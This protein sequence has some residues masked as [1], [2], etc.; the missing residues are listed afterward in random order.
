MKI[1]W[2][3]HFVPYPPAGGALQRSYHLLRHAATH[4]EVHLLALHQPR[5]LPHAELPASVAALSELCASVKV[6]DL[7]AERSTAHRVANMA[8]SVVS[9]SPFDVIWLRS[10]VFR[11]AVDEWQGS[12]LSLVHADTIGLW[13]YAERLVARTPV[14]LGHHNVESDFVVRR[15]SK[16]RAAWKGALLKN[17]ARKLVALERR[18][19]RQ[20][21]VNLVV[22]RLDGDRLARIVPHAAI[23]VVENGVDLDY[24][25]PSDAPPRDNTLIF[26]GTLGWHPNRDAVDYLVTEI[27]PALVAANSDRQL[28]LVGRDAGPI[29]RAAASDARIRVTGFVP[30]VRPY[31]R[32]ASVYVCPIRVGGG[33]RLKVLDALAMAKPLVASA[34]AVEGLDL[35]DGVHYLRAESVSDFVAQIGRLE[36]SPQLRATL[37]AAG[38]R[39]VADRFGWGVI[40]HQLETAY[41]R[42]LSAD[43]ARIEG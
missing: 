35:T 27:W 32:E 37:G 38:R 3:S 6:F 25:T 11:A 43:Q 30:D 20:A 34:I 12:D 4:H 28:T 15:A 9:A 17:D 40:G 1:L 5:L 39:L 2:L 26:A 36:A 21:A 10:P 29:A 19:G 33:T 7:P 41:Q 23:E 31:L 22:S 8:H 16:E 18:A 14:A 24:W 42:A 13:P